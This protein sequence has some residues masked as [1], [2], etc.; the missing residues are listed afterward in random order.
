MVGQIVAF[1]WRYHARQPV[2]FAGLLLFFFFGALFGARFAPSSLPVD[3][4][5]VVMQTGGFL[6]L[7]SIFAVA[8]FAASAVLRDAEHRMESIVYTMPVTKRDFLLGRFLGVFLTTLTVVAMSSLGMIAVRFTSLVEPERLGAF[9]LRA[10]LA[11]F[12]VLTVPNVLLAAAV[13]FAIA[14]AT[15]SA[16]ATYSGAVVLYVLYLI[17]AALTNSPIMAASSPGKGGGAAIA[18]LDPFGLSAFFE[19]TRLWTASLRSTRLIGLQPLLVMNRLLWLGAAAALWMLAFRRFTFQPRGDRSRRKGLVDD[20]GALDL[21]VAVPKP[22]DLRT[23]RIAPL[24][25]TIRIELRHLVSLPLLA[26]LALWIGLAASEIYSHVADAEYDVALLPATSLILD[27]VAQPLTIVG[28]AIV[29]FFGAEIAWREQRDGVAAIIESTPVAGGVLVAAKVAAIAAMAGVL[30]VAGILPGLLVQLLRGPEW[31]DAPA[32]LSLFASGGL[33]L[34][35]LGV[36]M[37]LI[38]A[39]SPGKYAGMLFSLLF[40]IVARQ[41]SLVGLDHPLWSYASLPPLR[42][43]EMAGFGYD[44]APFAAFALHWIVVASLLFAAAAIL[45]RGL[46]TPLRA[47]LRRLSRAPRMALLL[48][49]A[50]SIATGAFLFAHVDDEDR[51]AWQA[52]YE[53]TYKPLAARRQPRIAAIDAQFDFFE[54]RVEARARYEIVNASPQPITRIDVA[55]RRDAARVA[56]RIPGATRRSDARFGMHTFT[57]ARPLAPGARTELHFAGTLLRDRFSTRGDDAIAPNGSFLIAMRLLPTLGY[58][59]SYEIDDPAERRRRGLAPATA[60]VESDV[61]SDADDIRLALTVSTP[62]DQIA[63]A[64]GRIER[65]W[66]EGERRFTH[67]SEPRM[68]NYFAIAAARYASKTRS[69]NGRTIELHYDPAHS[70]NAEAALDIAAR[71]LEDCE[72]NFGPYRPAQLRMAEVPSYWPFGALAMPNT[73]FLTEHRTLLIDRRDPGRPD[74]LARRIAH[75]VAHQWWG[76]EVAPA[77]APGGTFLVESFAKYAELM[78]IER[79]HGRDAVRRLLDIERDRYLAGRAADPSG[80]VPLLGVE[81]QA[82]LYYAKGALVLYAI[83]DLVGEK[84]LHQALRTFVAAESQRHGRTVGRDLLPHLRSVATPAEYAQIEEWLGEVVLY[85]F[86]VAS[87]RRTGEGIE[88]RVQA[89]K[90]RADAIGNETRLPIRDAIDVRIL[91]AAGEVLYEARHAVSGDDVLRIA[92][93]GTPAE[94]ELDPW[95]LRIDTNLANNVRRV[96]RDG[97]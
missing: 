46:G 16:L 17:T 44:A 57:L 31:I 88:V 1:E 7:L 79:M 84:R 64:P 78:V 62:A 70:A 28:L 58:R 87:A 29:L 36:A 19:V 73:V 68:R 94:V 4:P 45:W 47:R 33:P 95:M 21:T 63:V 6:S 67:F 93:R 22:R 92:V 48:P 74:L 86:A 15:R 56:L 65:T 49:L 83:R 96:E 69:W 5:Y 39:L 97:R 91:D 37:L 60:A 42:F 51:T 85:D 43:T 80:E 82:H 55:V 77:S 26:L 8:V 25:S 40:V 54:R 76:Y 18:L 41:P 32:Y 10:H 34:V 9:D 53:R 71:S 14:I 38:H 81:N 52:E 72:R 27:S 35:V 20:A 61:P 23:S 13:M 90:V 11:S 24:L 66:I 75:E 30:V 3:T 12:A 50:A 89:G 2:F 59:R